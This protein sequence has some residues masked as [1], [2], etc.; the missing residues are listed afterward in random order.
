[1]KRRQKLIALLLVMSMGFA[2]FSDAALAKEPVDTEARTETA[3]EITDAEGTAEGKQPAESGTGTEGQETGKGDGAQSGKTEGNPEE[4][5]KAEQ[6]AEEKDAADTAKQSE[7]EKEAE[8][9]DAD[10]TEEVQAVSYTH[11]RAHET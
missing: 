8:P 5:P 11:L 10:I 7:P 2:V 6:L 3:A 9:E 1:M 4:K